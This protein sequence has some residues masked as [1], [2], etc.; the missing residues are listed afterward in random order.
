VGF[1]VDT[2][3]IAEL[4]LTKRGQR[5]VPQLLKDYLS[6]DSS[7]EAYYQYPPNIK[8]FSSAIANKSKEV[9][10]RSVLAEVIKK[11]YSSI[12]DAPSNISLLTDANTFTVTTGHQLCLFTGPL[13]LCYKI[14][15]V[16][17]LA[18]KLK[19]EYPDKNFVPLF[20][21]ASE[22]HDFEEVNHFHLFGKK[23]TWEA[24]A[25][26]AVGRMSV[27]GVKD[28]ITALKEQLQS[29]ESAIRVLSIFESA[30]S[31]QE[32][33]ANATRTLIHSLFGHYG[34]VVLDADD[35]ALK[36]SFVKVMK[37][38]V[39]RQSS[40]HAMTSAYTALSKS[41]KL[42]VKSRDVNL[43]YLHD[44][45]RSRLEIGEGD[46]VNV[47]DTDISFE[48]N[49]WLQMIDSNPENFSPNVVL[50]PLYQEMVLPNLAYIGGS[51]EITYWLE[52]KGIFDENEVNFPVLMPRN[53]LVI[54]GQG[55][56]KRMD[57]LKLSKAD[58]FSD[59]DEQVKSIVSQLSEDELSVATE[60]EEISAIYDKLVTRA[61]AVDASLERSVKA[62]AVRALAQLD[63]LE[64][65]LV[66]AAKKT[67]ETTINQV[68]KLF[69]SIFPEGVFQERYESLFSQLIRYD[70]G[71]IDEMK[72]CIEP[73]DTSLKILSKTQG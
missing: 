63:K 73:F 10:N 27:D 13:Y 7:L 25:G 14:L 68:N 22:D 28:V 3:T 66:K 41:Y 69:E 67:N 51:S 31:N 9:I 64:K 42:P 33:L 50:R 40:M 8:S 2:L 36:K 56:K 48:K 44:D 18:E 59:P 20:W 37:A 23:V 5:L 38:E 16:I 6:G 65:K 57:Q 24:E 17:N 60:R 45:K 62:D 15:T 52:L 19:Q 49:E 61:K 26:N 46:K 71:V 29:D 32:N 72:D 43:F 21:M 30:Y 55:E 47:V 4:D 70:F 11:Q 39:E 53:S 35:A 34:L 12:G 1:Q 54:L 58:L